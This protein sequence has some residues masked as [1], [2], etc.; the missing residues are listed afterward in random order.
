MIRLFYIKKDLGLTWEK[1]P[2]SL[3][4]EDC[5]KIVW[6]DL[7]SALEE[8]KRLVESHFKIELFT[9]QEAAE[10]ESSSR[11]FEDEEYIEANN[12]FIVY[13]DKSHT[14]DHVSFIVKKDILFT[15]RSADLRSFAHTVKNSRPSE[16]SPG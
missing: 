12:A 11:Y 10:I 14:T 3:N 2:V 1:D 9:P 6:V 16:Q 4:P 13:D 8:E 7:Q 5:E 15:L